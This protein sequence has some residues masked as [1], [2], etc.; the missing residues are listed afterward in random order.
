MNLLP[1]EGG[2]GGGGKGGGG[3]KGEKGWKRIKSNEHPVSQ[4]HPLSMSNIWI[5]DRGTRLNKYVEKIL[6]HKYLNTSKL[7]KAGQAKDSPG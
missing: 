6:H 2:E 3:K 1:T 7:T 5:T 4:K